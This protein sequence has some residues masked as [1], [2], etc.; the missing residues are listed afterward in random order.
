MFES[1][2]TDEIFYTFKNYIEPSQHGL[3]K[4]R[5]TTSNLA[6]FQDFLTRNVE[7]GYQIDVIYTDMAKAF[8]SISHKL[9]LNKLESLGVTGAYLNW[10]RSYLQNR[11][12]HVKL[13]GQVSKEIFVKSGV[14]QGSYLGPVLF[15]IFVNSVVSVFK[16][17]KFL[18]YAEELLELAN[19]CEKNLLMLNLKNCKI[20][21]FYRCKDSIISNYKV[22]ETE[23]DSVDGI[24]DLGV[25]FDAQLTFKAHIENIVLRGYRLLGFLKRTCFYICDTGAIKCLYNCLV[26]SVLEYNSVIWCPSYNCY[27]QQLE[28]VQNK[29]VKFLL[30]K[31]KIP[32]RDISRTVRLQLVGLETLEK[33][34][35]KALT[36]FL[37][38]IY[39]NLIDCPEL[40][41]RIL[42]NISVRRTRNRQL[43]VQSYH[44]TNYGQRCFIDRLAKN[45]NL[46]YNHI[47]I[48]ANSLNSLMR[49][50]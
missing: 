10:I 30:Y 20:M 42:I 36:I 21:R 39:N 17:C 26:R 18:M 3:Y 29:F 11:R 19:W 37:F 7:S 23:L 13:C 43:F 44:R 32:Y 47:D 2:I 35:E 50:L 46:H 6:V 22:R 34:R 38:K 12:Q 28:S 24:N 33:R 31:Y 14:P 40:L 15:L 1:I 27:I 45:Y 16:S 9:L 4:R 49:K 41:S 5:S 25:I 8:D 48:F